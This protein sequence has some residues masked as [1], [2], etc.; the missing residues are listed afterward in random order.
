MDPNPYPY[1]CGWCNKAF[2]G[3]YD[4]EHHL[5]HNHVQR[6][7]SSWSSSGVAMNPRSAVA[8]DRAVGHTSSSV[9]RSISGRNNVYNSIPQPSSGMNVGSSSSG[10]SVPFHMTEAAR[11]C[12]VCKT[13]FQYRAGLRKHIEIHKPENAAWSMLQCPQCGG[14]MGSQAAL[15]RHLKKCKKPAY[16]QNQS[17]A[18]R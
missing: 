18:S 2:M 7:F 1:S 14:G 16:L 10:G 13:V 11:T 15:T 5:A 8:G 6:Q 9:G 17:S 4:L 3:K 12:P